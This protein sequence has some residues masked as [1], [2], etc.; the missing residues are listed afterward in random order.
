MPNAAARAEQ[1]CGVRIG[2]R[3]HLGAPA[4]CPAGQVVLRDPAGTDQADAQ[5]RA[6]RQWAVAHRR[7]LCD[8]AGMVAAVLV[9]QGLQSLR[10]E[11]CMRT[12]VE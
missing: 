7:V 8:S 11:V 9:H 5:R 6:N 4:R 12:I 3:H 10:G 2:D 1:P